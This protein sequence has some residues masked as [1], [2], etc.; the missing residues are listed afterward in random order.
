MKRLS[1]LIFFVVV[2]IQANNV[3]DNQLL[4][5]IRTP[6]VQNRATL[7]ED[8]VLK[9]AN[10]NAQENG[11]TAIMYQIEHTNY[12]AE[13][14]ALEHLLEKASALKAIDFIAGNGMTAL[15]FAADLGN[16]AAME[17]I[18]SFGGKGSK[19]D[20]FG[21]TMQDYLN[22]DPKQRDLDR[23]KRENARKNAE[24]DLLAGEFEEINIPEEPWT[25]ID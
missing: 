23:I 8:L 14:A 6:N 18:I 24:L 11:K 21:K 16:E 20:A 22:V 2:G 13:I 15:T 19:K 25:M 12:R 9:G 7:V 17:R 10:P 5:I 1:L 4:K 3:L